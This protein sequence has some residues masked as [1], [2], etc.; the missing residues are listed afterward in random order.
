MTSPFIHKY[1]FDPEN[2][3]VINLNVKK[4]KITYREK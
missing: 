4:N 3:H 1:E 2:S